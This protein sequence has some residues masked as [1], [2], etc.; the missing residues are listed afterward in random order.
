MKDT[1]AT[2]L[3]QHRLRAGLTQ[4]QLAERTKL[5]KPP[6]G[7]DRTA[8]GKIESGKRDNPGLETL[9]ALANALGVTIDDL[10]PDAPQ[11]ALSRSKD[12]RRQVLLRR[13]SRKVEGVEDIE[14]LQRILAYIEFIASH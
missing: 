5:Y 1:L 4:A 2:L 7:V 14:M 8:I 6:K 12:T 9:Q 11:L 3:K 13:V 10:T